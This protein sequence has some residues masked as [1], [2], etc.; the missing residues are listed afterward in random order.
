MPCRLSH[1]VQA[2]ACR[3]GCHNKVNGD[4]GTHTHRVW[5]NTL[6]EAKLAPELQNTTVADY[7]T[8][9]RVNE[10]GYRDT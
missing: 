4:L 7:I 3:A 6:Q 10:Q 9:P 1:A 5:T 8:A 2:V